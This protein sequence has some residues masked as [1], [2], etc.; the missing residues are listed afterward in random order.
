MI[1]KIFDD[2]AV[3]SADTKL[4]RRKESNKYNEE[5]LEELLHGGFS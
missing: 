1:W 2:P 3:F 5:L 4:M